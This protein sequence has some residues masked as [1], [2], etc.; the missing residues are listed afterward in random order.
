MTVLLPGLH[1][2]SRTTLHCLDPRT[3]IGAALVLAVLPFAAPSPVSSLI[4]AAF[5]IAALG[6]ARVPALSALRALRAVLWMGLFILAFYSL[7][8]PGQ[9]VA[10]LGSVSLTWEGLANGLQQ[11]F[12][13]SYLVLLSALLTYATSPTQVAHGIEAM[14]GPLQHLGLP[15]REFAM[16]MTIALRFV[17]TLAEEI[18]QLV[19]AQEARGAAIRSGPP[20]QRLRGWTAVVVPTIVSAFRRADEL[21]TAMDAR[22]FRGVRGRTHLYALRLRRRDGIAGLI[23]LIVIAATVGAGWCL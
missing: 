19:K 7:T 2:P 18:D 20:G 4:A 21:A 14:F 8:T 5:L 12:R 1:V 13:L 10:A 23:V 17:P 9:P 16:V 3:K 11:V 6:L 22:G 15:V